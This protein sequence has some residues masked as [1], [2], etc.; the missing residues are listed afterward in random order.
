MHANGFEVIALAHH[1]KSRI[2][3]SIPI[4]FGD[5]HDVDSLR[6]AVEGIDVVC[7]LAGL[8]RA[9]ES[10][11]LPLNRP[12]CQRADAGKAMSHWSIGSRFRPPTPGEHTV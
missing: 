3:R 5:L 2:P 7:H 8:T 9:R 12:D 11:A 1:D 10:V 4:R 6:D